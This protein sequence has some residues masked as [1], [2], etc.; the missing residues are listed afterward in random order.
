MERPEVS[1]FSRAASIA[2]TI[3]WRSSRRR[4]GI[5]RRPDLYDAT[6]GTETPNKDAVA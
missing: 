2:A 5:S 4:I 1:Q 3:R 6:S